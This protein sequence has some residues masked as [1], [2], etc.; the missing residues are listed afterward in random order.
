MKGCITSSVY[1]DYAEVIE[2]RTE[3]V[4]LWYGSPFP[5]LR[6]AVNK[7]RANKLKNVEQLKLNIACSQTF[8]YVEQ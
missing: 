5:S 7:D 8:Y 4:T 1:A 2:C 3:L 6:I